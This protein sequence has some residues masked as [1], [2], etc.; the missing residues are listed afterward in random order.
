MTA[1]W[2]MLS[3]GA[4]FKTILIYKLAA[5]AGSTQCWCLQDFELLA[6]K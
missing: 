1:W 2:F 3:A 4:S 6:D 5:C